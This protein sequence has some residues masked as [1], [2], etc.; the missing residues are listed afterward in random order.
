MTEQLSVE[1]R[2]KICHGAAHTHMC[3]PLYLFRIKE[4][5]SRAVGSCTGPPASDSLIG[6]VLP[7]GLA[8]IS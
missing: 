4:L 1:V 7:D 6:T 8:Q 5:D 2:C 3:I